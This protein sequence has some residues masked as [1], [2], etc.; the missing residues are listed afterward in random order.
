MEEKR[1][2]DIVNA[3][4]DYIDT[5]DD[6]EELSFWDV[7]DKVYGYLG[8]DDGYEFNGFKIS[9]NEFREL[10]SLFKEQAHHQGY[11]LDDSTYQDMIGAFPFSLTFVVR[12]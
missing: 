1:Q 8:F 7:M 12:K 10:D 6:G 11:F 5:L 3:C 4:L 9:E 2:M